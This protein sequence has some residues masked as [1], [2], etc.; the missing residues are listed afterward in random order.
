M[1]MTG[2]LD[3][4][5]MLASRWQQSVWDGPC[6]LRCLLVAYTLVIKQVIVITRVNEQRIAILLTQSWISHKEPWSKKFALN[7]KYGVR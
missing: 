6:C 5:S 2:R 7:A 1:T 4:K 3:V